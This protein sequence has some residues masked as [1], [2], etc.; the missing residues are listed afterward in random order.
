MRWQLR[1]YR[2]APGRLDDFVAEWRERVVPLR[3]AA[4]FSIVGP[5]VAP[6]DDRFVWIVGHEELEEAN[7]AYYES[8]ARQALDPDPARHIAEIE[9]ELVIEDPPPD[10]GAAR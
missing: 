5:W 6:E 7:A 8:A 4:G 2:I 3:L 1:V 10:G 9:Q